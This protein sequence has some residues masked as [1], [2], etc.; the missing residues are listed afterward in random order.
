LQLLEF[1]DILRQRKFLLSAHKPM[2]DKSR[3]RNGSWTLFGFP[4]GA[5]FETAPGPFLRSD[6]NLLNGP[7]TGLQAF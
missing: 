6:E 3:V 7:E 4:K 1:K 5:V 2:S